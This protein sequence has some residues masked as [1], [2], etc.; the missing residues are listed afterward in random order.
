[1]TATAMRRSSGRER[2]RILVVLA[3]ASAGLT[4]LAYV[5]LAHGPSTSPWVSAT[6]ADAS[7]TARFPRPPVV[8]D[9][10]LGQ[11]TLTWS[12]GPD[13]L[14][15]ATSRPI[16]A[17]DPASEQQALDAAVGSL[18]RRSA[19]SVTAMS[20]RGRPARTYRVR[21]G[22]TS[23][24]GIFF[25]DGGVLFSAVTVGPRAV[26]HAGQFFDSIHPRH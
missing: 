3:V 23:T 9:S 19:D 21:S 6:A 24:Q 4:L 13:E 8:G 10:S 14:Y 26:T 25:V 7:F 18:D 2:S 5:V 1:M 20:F 15:L 11:S 17:T 22:T 16:G 12:D